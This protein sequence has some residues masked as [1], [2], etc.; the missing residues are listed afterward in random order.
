M[1]NSFWGKFGQRSN[2]TQ[3][4]T[5][6]KPDKF[7]NILQDDS[8]LIHRVEIMNDEMVEIFHSF[9]QDCDPIQVNVNIFIA[10][11]TTCH[12]RLK[13]YEALDQLQERVLYFDTDSVVYVWKPG[14]SRITTGN[15]LG[16]FTSELQEEDY[17][18]EFVAA[19]P[20]NYA[21][22]TK[23]GDKCCKVRGFTLNTRGQQ[24]LNFSSMKDLVLAEILEPEEDARTLTLN[25]PH[26]IMRE[27]ATKKIK[28]VVQDKQYK[29]VFDK[30]ILD[31]NTF[32][33]YPYGFKKGH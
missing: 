31:T 19:G 26:K 8:Q 27:P 5:C 9:Q 12:A 13:L 21:Y 2:L 25:N 30:R 23:N 11:F 20:K 33:S 6:N 22:V 28:T 7:F 24:V 4:T 32:R 3:V 16:D 15:Y 29:L 17:I 10:C 18:T 1:L 14:Q